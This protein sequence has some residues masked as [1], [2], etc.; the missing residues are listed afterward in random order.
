M[1]YDITIIGAGLM[2]NAIARELSKYKIDVAVIEK[3]PDLYGMSSKASSAIVH[4]GFHQKPGTLKAK[5]GVE[6]NILFPSLC[7]ELDVPFKRLGSL[8]LAL[9]EDDMKILEFQKRQGEINGVKNLKIVQLEELKKMEDN[10]SSEVI[11]A[12]YSPMCG[13]VSP[14]ELAIAYMENAI[15]NGV[16]IFIENPVIK[17]EKINKEWLVRTT[18]REIRTKYIINCAGIF[19]DEISKLAGDDSFKI[20]PLKGEEYILDRNVG[21]L[22]KHIIEI[23]SLGVFMMPTVHGNLMIGTNQVKTNKNDFR[24]TKEGFK[25]IFS[26]IQ[27]VVSG[28]LKEDIITSFAGLRPTNNKSDDYIIEAPK[29]IDNFINVS[30]GSPGIFAA[31]AIARTVIDILNNLGLILEEKEDYNRFRKAI[32]EF[33][34]LTDD[35]KKE[36]INKDEKYGHVICRCETVTEGQIIEA[37]KRGTCTLD[38]IKY[39]TR[40]GMGRCQGGFCTSRILKIMS[41]ELG[42][43]VTEITKKGGSSIIMPFKAKELFREDKKK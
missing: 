6:S 25:N 41:R 5:L 23:P 28:I 26:K 7:N 33:K 4:S 14:Y 15:E 39:R 36:F 13:I 19:A 30:I 10:I 11:A 27:K 12:L 9:N 18:K 16:K 17:I 24:T 8:S 38:G 31:P 20:I 2:G 35:E 37:I 22:V 42:I 32:V 29:K 43:S 21:N 40:A 34:S 1:S 3:N